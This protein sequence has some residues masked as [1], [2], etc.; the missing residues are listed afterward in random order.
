MFVFKRKNIVIFGV[1]MLVIIAFITVLGALIQVPTAKD[2]SLLTVV[3]DAGHGGID[4]GVSGKVTGVRESELNLIISKK[5]GAYF[6]SAKFRVVYTRST[7][8]GLY[9]V[10][11]TS[12]KKKDM[13]KRKEIILKTKPS[14]V[15]SIHMNYYTLSSRRGGQVFYKDKDENGKLLAEC[16]QQSFNSMEEASRTCNILTGDYY[17]LNCS[18]CPSVIAECGFLSNKEDELLLTNSDYQDKIAYAIFKGS[19]SYLASCSTYKPM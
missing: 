5:L 12:L 18:P 1:F 15:I 8:A 14:L 6:K 2:D 3:I 19:I 4:N 16:I 9:G 10:V 11:T 7:D 17:I 13:Q